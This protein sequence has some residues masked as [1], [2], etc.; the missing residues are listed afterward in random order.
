MTN[1]KIIDYLCGNCKFNNCKFNNDGVCLN[2]DEEFLLNI[3][4]KVRNTFKDNDFEYILL[5]SMVLSFEC[6]SIRER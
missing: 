4:N 6:K 1:I 3:F 2:E 5:Y